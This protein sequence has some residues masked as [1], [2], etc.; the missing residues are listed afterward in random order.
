MRIY[1]YIDVCLNNFGEFETN[2]I[3]I[4]LIFQLTIL[5]LNDLFD[6]PTCFNHDIFFLKFGKLA[7]IKLS[8]K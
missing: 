4:C 3:G 5:S 2:Q 8:P 1:I 7:S 6:I